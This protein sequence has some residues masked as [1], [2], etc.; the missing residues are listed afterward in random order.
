MAIQRY[1]RAGAGTKDGSSW[2]NTKA[3]EAI[4][5][6]L[7]SAAPDDSFLIG[8]DRDREDPV[9]WTD[10]PIRL[11]R[12]G[13]EDAPI[14]IA[15]GYISQPDNVQP[16]G[17]RINFRRSGDGPLRLAQPALRGPMF[18]LLK[19]GASNI[20]VAGFGFFG[21]P[22]DG[23]ISFGED[24]DGSET[25]S[26]IAISSLSG[27]FAGRVL[28]SGEQAVVNRL[29]VEGCDALGL[30]RGFASFYDLSDSV[31][32]NLHLD[33]GGVDGGGV[34][35][36]QLFHIR[37]G[38]NVR[39]ENIWMKGGVNGL[40]TADRQSDYIQGDGIVCEEET[41]GFVFRN[42]HAEGMGDGGYDL[43][44]SAFLMEDCS[45]HGCKKGVRIWSH[46]QNVLR[47]CAFTNPVS[48]ASQPQSVWCAGTADL[49][50]CRLQAGS[51]TSIFR[52]AKG[53]GGD[54]V[55]RMHGGEIT[56]DGRAAL[57]QGDPGT[58]ELDGVR[59]NGEL[60]S[61]TIVSTGGPV[62]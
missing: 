37:K 41:T 59:V 58:L 29:R 39:F 56:T 50:D 31:F 3:F 42:C 14:R 5:G 21:A 47:R 55:I 28:E 8:F 35:T 24:E 36:S 60:R 2:D 53:E 15:A 19:G 54:P 30:V 13:E 9:F 43:K 20:E 40:A 25:F 34:S 27:T 7:G 6:N 45:A 1:T 57:I 26:D 46:T 10:T 44:S 48:I 11:D 4:T 22:V 12:S 17:M 32:R 18:I 23:F 51:G 49:F 16:S 33:A 38:T 52:F 62:R 61:E